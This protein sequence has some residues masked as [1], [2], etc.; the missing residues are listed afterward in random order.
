MG[1]KGGGK[2]WPASLIISAHFSRPFKRFSADCVPSVPVCAH[3]FLTSASRFSCRALIQ[4][5]YVLHL[6]G[7]VRNH[8]ARQPGS[9]ALTSFF[10]LGMSVA[11]PFHASTKQ[12]LFFSAFSSSTNLDR[13][14]SGTPANVSM[15]R[16]AIL[17][18]PKVWPR[19]MLIA[20]ACRSL[21]WR[22]S[23]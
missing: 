8:S 23:Q 18:N 19:S 4:W 12:F 1:K 17:P 20:H 22:S 7:T 16:R 2:T 3:D 11:E 10:V 21:G 9:S 5:Q 13:C 14:L 15:R 6:G